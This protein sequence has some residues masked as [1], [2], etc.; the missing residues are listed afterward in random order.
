MRIGKPS[1]ATLVTCVLLVL[2][3]ALAILQYR[4]VGQVSTAERERMQRNLR[5]AAGQ[6]RDYF[7]GEIGRAVLNLQVGPATAIEGASERYTDRY[8]TWLNTSAHPQV[9]AAVLLVDAEEGRLRL[10]RWDPDTHTFEATEWPAVLGEWRR[11]FEQELSDFSAGRPST[12]RAPLRGEDSIIVMPLRNLVMPRSPAPV[13]QTVTPV[14]GFTIIELNMTYI[15]EQML[16]ELAQRHFVHT[17]GD[18]YRVAVTSADDPTQVLYRSDPGAPLEREHADATAALLRRGDAGFLNPFPRGVDPDGDRPPG[19]RPRPE[20]TASGTGPRRDDSVGRW[21]L[22]VQHQSGSLEAAV[23]AARRRNLGISFGVLLLLTVSVALLANASRRAQRLARQQMEFVA[24]VSHE[25]R[26]PVAVIRSASENLAHGVVSGE[27]VKSYGQLLQTEAR[28]LGEMVERVLQFAGIESGL[29]FATRVSLS[30]S[31][32]IEGAID[33]S[34]PLLENGAVQIHREIAADLPPVLGDAQALRS[35]VQ[36]LI[37]NAVKYGGRDRWVGIRAEHAQVR[38]RS[39]V[40][41]TV[42]DHGNGIPASELPHIFDPFYRGAD[43]VERQVHGNG[44]GLS[45]VKRIVAAHGGRVT[46]TSKA[47]AGSSFTISLPAIPPD[48]RQRAV[49]ELQPVGDSR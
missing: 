24:G 26:T 28:R 9:V 11:R 23:S 33:S 18:G 6:F 12:R 27:R 7:D 3:P 29:G 2:L 47:G 36:N 49:A 15:R 46:V 40:R 39:E 48:A 30:P 41:I 37:A 8:E 5:T 20:D 31:E 13:T 42:S 21:V 25:L 19:R 35:A 43:A 22:L 10:R 14:F 32:I 17:E 1:G 44:L 34:L 16:P 38:R 4:W 45:L